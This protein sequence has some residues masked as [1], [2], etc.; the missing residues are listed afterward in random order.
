MVGRF[1]SSSSSS[2]SSSSTFEAN[3]CSVLAGM[4]CFRRRRNFLSLCFAVGC[5]RFLGFLVP[6][7]VDSA[8]PL[9]GTASCSGT[10]NFPS[11]QVPPCGTSHCESRAIALDPRASNH[12]LVTELLSRR[13]KAAVPANRRPDV[14]MPTPPALLRVYA[15]S[16]ATKCFGTRRLWASAQSLDHTL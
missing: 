3:A 4:G 15:G 2:I 13:A 6:A 10:A 11:V 9:S 12:S 14:T 7:S 5:C 1:H 16:N 8:G